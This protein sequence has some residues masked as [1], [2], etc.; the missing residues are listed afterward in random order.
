MGTGAAS[1]TWPAAGGVDEI[2]LW[3]NAV[4]YHHIGGSCAIVLGALST[5]SAFVVL[6][7]YDRDQLVM[8]MKRLHPTRMGG[9]PTKL[10][11]PLPG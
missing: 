11:K 10:R 3:L 4:P 9:V 6:E 2:D 8:L 7:G 5:A 1:G